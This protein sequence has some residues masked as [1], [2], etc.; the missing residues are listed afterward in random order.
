MD[1]AGGDGDCSSGSA[2]VS[3]YA[4]HGEWHNITTSKQ[5]TTLPIPNP[6][7]DQAE[8]LLDAHR[9]EAAHD[10]LTPWMKD[11]PKAPDRDRAVF[12]LADVYFQAGSRDR[13]KSF[14]FLDELMDKFPESRFYG[15]AIQKQYQIADA[16][17]NGYKNSFLF[18]HILT[19]EDEAIEMLYRIQERAPG[20]A[21]AERCL[22]RTADYYFQ[23]SQ[24]DLAADV[25]ASYIRS[26]PRSPEVPFVKLRAA[27]AS[28]AQFRGSRYDPTPL[29]DARAQFQEIIEKYP[30]MAAEENVPER[31]QRI[32]DTLARK[33][34]VIAS[35]YRR[36]NQ[37]A[38]AVYVY[39]SLMETYP[40]GKEAQAAQLQLNLMPA[41]AL[42]QPPAARA[43]PLTTQPANPPR[44]LGK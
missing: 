5:P 35:F 15:L 2:K 16:Y 29:I 38:A 28:L 27:F 30:D 18:L 3:E 39:R 43:A 21:I 26:Y 11:N 12:L 1:S 40:G 36:T 8:R 14:Y 9:Y 20:S 24:F 6:T 17:L 33:L 4:G 7:L 25:F 34:Y 32:D 23:T 22:L 37:P 10:I 31:I 13:F 44:G 41:S 42:A 19:A